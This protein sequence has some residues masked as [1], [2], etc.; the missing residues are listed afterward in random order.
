M[1]EIAIEIVAN[2]GFAF[3]LLA[4]ECNVVNSA[5]NYV[6]NVG[7]PAQIH[8][9]FSR[10]HRH[11]KAHPVAGKQ[12]HAR[13]AIE[14]GIHNRDVAA[15]HIVEHQR[16]KL[17]VALIWQGILVGIQFNVGDVVDRAAV[18]VELEVGNCVQY[19]H[20][21]ARLCLGAVDTCCGTACQIISGI[22]AVLASKRNTHIGGVARG[23][24]KGIRR[25]EESHVDA[26]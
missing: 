3:L 13:L 10:S 25:I 21:Y 15:A 23:L 11:A 14:S 24:H 26:S 9:A 19:L 5:G 6:V 1:G 7:V 4:V 18:A 12:R 2:L 17:I 8:F 16:P 22:H 20:L